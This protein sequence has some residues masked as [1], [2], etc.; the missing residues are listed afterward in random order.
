MVHK[1]SKIKGR[2]DVIQEYGKKLK[3]PE[4]RVWIHPA[5]RGDDY[6]FTFKTLRG[7]K[8][9]T[10]KNKKSGEFAFVESPLVAYKGYEM[11]V[12]DF[13]KQFPKIKL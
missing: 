9:F 12:K 11:R 13:T 4:I 6:Y 3:N 7:A 8:A 1:K 10:K 2:I 5:G